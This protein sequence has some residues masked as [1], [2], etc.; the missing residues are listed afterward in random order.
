VVI[1]VGG[2]VVA[3]PV[4]TQ[5]IGEYV[6]LLKKLAKLRHEVILV[7][8]GGTL[9]REFIQHAKSLGLEEPEQD[10]AAI[11]VSRL[12]AQLF[13][14]KLGKIGTGTVP[15]SLEEVAKELGTAKI[16]VMGGLKP[17]MTTD[18][19]AALVAENVKGDLLVKATDQEGV[20]TSDPRKHKDAR[21]LDY[22]RFDDLSRFFAQN[23]HK[24]GIHQI[25]DPE[26]VKILSK[27]RTKTVVVSGFKPRN[28]LL[29]VE[30]KKVGTVI[31]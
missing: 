12:I 15:S 30:G 17:G 29:A 28:V 9:A 5:L 7:V 3:S 25:I 26:A 10:M 18:A 24:A 22:L 4:N 16:I 31:E 13:V 11:F 27:S 6:E 8:G 19:V 2:S 20:Y 1:R 21:K 14:L 23:K